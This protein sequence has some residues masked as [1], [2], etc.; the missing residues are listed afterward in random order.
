MKLN[1]IMTEQIREK[2][3]M[4][5]FLEVCVMMNSIAIMQGILKKFIL[6]KQ[7][8]LWGEIKEG[9]PA[10]RIVIINRGEIMAILFWMYASAIQ[11]SNN[12]KMKNF[13][14]GTS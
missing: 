2:F 4:I 8:V 9:I 10:E 6:K 5:K 11:R 3:F 14:N 12:I 7:K 1:N 13:A